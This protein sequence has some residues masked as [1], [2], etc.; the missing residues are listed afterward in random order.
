MERVSQPDLKAEDVPLLNVAVSVAPVDGR[1]RPARPCST[2]H[3]RY[4]LHRR[5][6]DVIESLRTR[7]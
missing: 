6:T 2:C 4:A 3:R 1:R 7:T 5:F